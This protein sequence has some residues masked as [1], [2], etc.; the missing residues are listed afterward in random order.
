MRAGPGGGGW[1]A[2]L[3]REQAA[4]H[5]RGLL[6]HQPAL[7]CPLLHARSDK[8]LALRRITD[9]RTAATIP[10]Y[11][12]ECIHTHLKISCQIGGSSKPPAIV[13]AA[14]P[15]LVPA[16]AAS[17]PPAAAASRAGKLGVGGPRGDAWAANG[18]L[19]PPLPVEGLSG[20]LPP[21]PT[22]LLLASRARCTCDERA[23]A[24][25]RCGDSGGGLLAAPP[26]CLGFSGGRSA[27]EEWG[28]GKP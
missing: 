2:G 23:P 15:P 25:A 4:K 26:G 1:G 27:A 19:P 3:Y 13:P 24:A 22:A 14:G 9:V 16:P 20:A 10:H 28:V 8:Q 5:P 17:A 7:C 12:Q 21:P 11:C 18:E 6:Q